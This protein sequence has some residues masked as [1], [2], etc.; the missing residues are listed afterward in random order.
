MYKKYMHIWLLTFCT[1]FFTYHYGLRSAIPSVLNED[2]QQYF[3][4]TASQIG[5]M[6]SSFYLAYTLMQIP[7]GLIL[8][9]FSSKRV[10]VIAFILFSMC[11][12]LF[13]SSDSIAVASFSQFLMGCCCSVVFVLL[14]KVANDYFPRDK[15]AFVS[16]VAISIGSLGPVIAS[17]TLT[18]LSTIIHWKTVVLYASFIGLAFSVGGFLLIKEAY[19]PKVH[20]ESEQ[21]DSIIANLKVVLTNPQYFWIGLFSMLM[22]GP[23]SSFCDAWGISFLKHVYNLNKEQAALANGF[24]FVGNI[25]GGPAIAYIALK[26]RSYREVMFGGAF[27]L[28]V[29]FALINWC[30]LPGFALHFALFI[31][32]S[33]LGSQFLSFPA[34]LTLATK[35]VGATVT[36]VVNTIT[37][38]GSTLLIK[39][40]GCILDISKGENLSYSASDYQLGVALMIACTVAA[41]LTV[42]LIKV[43]YPAAESAE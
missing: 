35:E 15:I 19:L 36:G 37:M 26:L 41:G 21:K 18:Y 33:L 29:T 32:G 5:T 17:S 42:C 31:I 28:A 39:G 43:K 38:M 20:H 12:M 8:D 10:G 27:G 11:L 13:V 34:A 14:M 1:I 40:V 23:V 7:V 3:N 25:V 30:A 16:S 22:L 6:I 2:L 4:A 24:V 9:R